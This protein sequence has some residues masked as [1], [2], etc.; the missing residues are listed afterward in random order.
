MREEFQA[1]VAGLS[2]LP[3]AE[4]DEFIA[5]VQEAGLE[6]TTAAMQRLQQTASQAPVDMRVA[7]YVKLRDERA[8]NT[9]NYEVADKLYKETLAAI[10]YS[11]IH[12]AQEQGVTGFKTAAGTTYMEERLSASIADENV[13]FDFVKAQGD[14]DFFERRIKIAHI[15][16]WA[17]ANGGTMPPGLNYF[18]EMS[19]KVRRA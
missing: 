13:F 18:R 19:M 4:R 9:K 11:L 8:A 15:K 6:I 17:A 7:K 10:E 12:D 2:L 5:A 16:E 3:K 1:V 14:L